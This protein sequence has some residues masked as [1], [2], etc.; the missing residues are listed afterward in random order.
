MMRLFFRLK[1]SKKMNTVSNLFTGH[2]SAMNT[3]LCG[4]I[5]PMNLKSMI[6]HQYGDLCKFTGPVY[7]FTIGM[8]MMCMAVTSISDSI[9]II[10]GQTVR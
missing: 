3:I 9:M 6:G 5:I 10:R 1:R 7:M 8:T 4:V 2:I